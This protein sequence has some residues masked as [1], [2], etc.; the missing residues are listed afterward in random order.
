MTYA[1]VKTRAQYGTEAK[2]VLVEVHL[3]NGL[4]SFSIVGLPDKAVRESKDRVRSALLSCQ[5]ELPHRHITVNLSPADLPKDGGRFDLPIALGILHASKQI[6]FHTL[7]HYCIAGELSLDGKLKPIQGALPFAYTCLKE[8]QST[9]LPTANTSALSWLPNL[10]LYPANHLLDV[11][12]HLSGQKSLTAQTFSPI[13]DTH[14]QVGDYAEVQGQLQAKRA[15]EIAAAGG[16]N[17]MMQGPPG[18]GKSMLASRLPSILPPLT[19][20][21]RIELSILYSLTRLQVYPN[22][23]RPFR[24]PHHSSSAV[25]LIGG[26]SIP[27]PG[28]ISLA[29][30]GALFLDELPEFDRK[31][32]EVMRQPLETGEVHI[33]RARDHVCF[34]ARFQLIAAM[35]PCPC[36]Y[37]SENSQ[38]CTC[39]HLQIQR[40]QTKLSGPLLDRIDLHIWV[41]ALTP[42]ELHQTTEGECSQAIKERVIAAQAIQVERQNKLNHQLT[43][44]QLMQHLSVSSNAKQLLQKAS[45]QFQLSARRYYRVLRVARTIADLSASKQ[46]EVAHMAEAL[47][48]R[49]DQSSNR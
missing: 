20:N 4:P 12:A 37:L 25:A 8:Q 2:P 48:L 44:K 41:N 26:G 43:A 5:F 40:Y 47:S 6:Q 19:L 11:V 36:G 29:H 31:V 22:Q 38:R 13:Q 39:S 18:A 3:S 21:E 24:Q 9:I 17:L 1:A 32:L 16:H 23:Q 28:E 46:I 15:F 14:P 33:A 45:E 35:N 42:E 10:K 34:P 7:E 30:H 49:Q 27:K